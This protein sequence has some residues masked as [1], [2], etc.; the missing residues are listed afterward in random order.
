MHENEVLRSAVVKGL[1]LDGGELELINRQSLK[2]LSADDVYAF[3]IAACNNQVDRDYEK[4]SDAALADMATL[5]IGKTMVYDH[6][7]SASKQMARIYAATVEPMPD[8]AGG[9]Q[10]VLRV[11]MLKTE[12]T[13]D[14][15]A[16]IEG[17]ILREVSVGARCD[18]AICGICGA[19]KRKVFCEHRRGMVYDG[20]T[21]IV[22]LDKVSD[23]YELSFVAVPAQPAAGV[24]KNYGGEDVP[25]EGANDQAKMKAEFDLKV[26]LRKAHIK[27]LKNESED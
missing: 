8:V 24:T 25:P 18:S 4:F 20:T 26:R 1:K 7:W 9:K 15:V 11:Y 13:A 22:Q 19:D 17:G 27:M 12:S 14:V 21:C 3:K 6:N 16:Q 2:V 10:L 5:Y 23:A